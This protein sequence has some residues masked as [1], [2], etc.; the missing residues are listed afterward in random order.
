MTPYAL[1]ILPSELMASLPLRRMRSAQMQG[2]LRSEQCIWR[3]VLSSVDRSQQDEGIITLKMS[4]TG[5]TDEV[6]QAREEAL[7]NE[8]S[9]KASTPQQS[10]IRD[11]TGS[12]VGNNPDD[13]RQDKPQTKASNSP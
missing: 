12:G 7:Q 10:S 13:H 3:A 1:E 5:T 11:H 8:L 6:R 2:L 9:A 4:Y